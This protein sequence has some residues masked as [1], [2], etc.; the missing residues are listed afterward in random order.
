MRRCYLKGCF[1]AREWNAQ[2]DL[3]PKQGTPE[4]LKESRRQSHTWGR[5]PG[6]RAGGWPVGKGAKP[7]PGCRL[8]PGAY[9]LCHHRGPHTPKGSML[10]LI[11][12]FSIM[13]FVNTFWTLH[14]CLAPGPTNCIAVLQ[15]WN[16]ALSFMR[17]AVSGKPTG[18]SKTHF[19]LPWN[20]GHDPCFKYA[21]VRMKRD[22][23]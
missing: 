12:C 2:G 7:G 21:V 20:A 3:Y 13:K 23:E 19:L 5:M 4:E 22:C 18:L 9:G 17:G 16:P 1:R 6:S 11:L 14:F 15:F 8:V 10:G